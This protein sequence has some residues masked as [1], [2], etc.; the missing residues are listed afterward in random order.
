MKKSHSK[1][2]VNRSLD[3]ET[4]MAGLKILQCEIGPAQ[5]AM[6]WKK[7]TMLS[8]S[9]QKLGFAIARM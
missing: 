5:L 2:L 1:G 4:K 3:L 9:F 8:M 6:Q 7:A